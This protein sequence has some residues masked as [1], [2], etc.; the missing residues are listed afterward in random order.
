[1]FSTPDIYSMRWIDV[2]SCLRETGVG[3]KGVRGISNIAIHL[4][5]YYLLITYPFPNF[6]S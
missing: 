6:C 1:M 2:I 4:N 5:K 3:N